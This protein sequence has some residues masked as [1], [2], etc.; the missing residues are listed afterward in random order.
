MEIRA[1]FLPSRTYS[2]WKWAVRGGLLVVPL[3]S[4]LAG[5]LLLYLSPTLYRSTTLVEFE[6][7]PPA[8]ELAKLVE[9]RANLT[10]VIDQLQLV[11]LLSLD[12]DSAVEALRDMTEVTVIPDTGL[13]EIT[14]TFRHR[15]YARDIAAELV[16]SLKV[17]LTDIVTTTG[18]TKAEHLGSLYANATDV[19]EQQACKVVN[20]EKLHGTSPAEAGIATTLER[21]RRAALLADAEVERLHSLR[22]DCLTQTID[23]LPHVIV[24]SDPVVSQNPFSPQIEQELGKLLSHALLLGLITALSLPYLLELAFPPQ[25]RKQFP[26]PSFTDAE[27]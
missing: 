19:A 23:T 10:H 20:L 3:A 2:R 27:T 5:A 15:E 18:K 21:A 7:A 6:N 16:R 1:R 11:K 14:V 8:R 12:H 25:R 9:S 24:H 4:F 13:L 26:Q 22:N 17:Y